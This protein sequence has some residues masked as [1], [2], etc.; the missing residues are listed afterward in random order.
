MKLVL[1]SLH[2]PGGRVSVRVF[3]KC[4]R[5]LIKKGMSFVNKYQELLLAWSL[6][7]WLTWTFGEVWGPELVLGTGLC[8]V[9]LCSGNLA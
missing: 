1:W 2:M 4:W 8:S 5:F 3:E 9:P 6:M 7:A